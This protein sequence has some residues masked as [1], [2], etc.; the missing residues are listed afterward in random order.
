MVV[1]CD[2][3]S[4]DNIEYV[5]IEARY[6]CK[7]VLCLHARRKTWECPGGHVEMGES[8]IEAAR[9][10]LFEETGAIEFELIP[11]WDYRVL[12]EDG[13]VHN[14]GR[15]FFA[16]I[17]K[18]KDL[19]SE[20]EMVK[21]GFFDVLPSNVTYDREE[22]IRNLYRAAQIFSNKDSRK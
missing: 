22:M 7:W 8:P 5:V 12:K 17:T 2:L 3:N 10:E 11:V 4:L 19:P 16:E 9:R 1:E 18:F 14:N 20:S 15:T 13:S 21:I 6:M